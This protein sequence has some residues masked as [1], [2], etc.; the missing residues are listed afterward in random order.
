MADHM[1]KF[2][3]VPKG[4]RF[5]QFKDYYKWPSFAALFALIVLIIF[6]KAALFAPKYDA[7]LLVSTKETLLEDTIK[8][9][10]ATYAEKGLNLNGDKIN[11]VSITEITYSNEMSKKTPNIA[12]AM[13]TKLLAAFASKEN[14]IQIVD[15]ES[16]DAF[17]AQDYIGTYKDLGAKGD[18]FDKD[19]SEDVKIPLSCVP[20]FENIDALENKDKL[21]LTIRPRIDAQLKDKDAL[22]EYERQLDVF[23]SFFN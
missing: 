22:A 11:S 14:I 16:Y 12:M 6:I 18:I 19:K 4:Q 8:Q 5:Q 13:Q 15:D 1:V 21:Y 23:F 17:K 3:E 20:F 9:I 7:F 10:E 2:S